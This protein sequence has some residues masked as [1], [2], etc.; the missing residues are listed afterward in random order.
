MNKLP[1]E[2]IS[3]IFEYDGRYRNNYNNLIKELKTKISWHKVLTQT[4]REYYKYYHNLFSK[5]VLDE[6]NNSETFIFSK[7][8]FKYIYSNKNI[9]YIF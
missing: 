7:F 3:K 8:F 5:K 9:G 6:I 2:L 4:Q 1:N